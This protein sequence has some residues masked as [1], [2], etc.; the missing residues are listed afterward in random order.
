M[1]L[2]NVP[3]R[4]CR[5]WEKNPRNIKKSDFARLKEQK[6]ELG[7]YKPLVAVEENGEYTILGGNMRLRALKEMGQEE[8]AIVL[9]KAETEADKIKIALSDNDRA[10][11]YDD[12]AV[13]ELVWPH[14]EHIDLDRYHIDMGKSHTIATILSAFGPTYDTEPEDMIPKMDPDSTAKFGD[15]YE[16]QDHRLLCADATDP[17]AYA[18]LMDGKKADLV[19]TDPPYNVDY[20]SYDKGKILSDNMKP[21]VFVEFSV[22]FF[23]QLRQNIKP[24]GVF[25]VCSGYASYPTFIYAIKRVGLIF[26]CPIIWI[27]DYFSWGWNDY[28]HQHE[29]LLKVK[30]DKRRSA[31]PIL[32]GWNKGRHFF[33]DVRNEADVW[34]IQRRATTTMVHPTQKPL[35]LIKRA[36]RNS[37]KKGELILD[38]FAGGGSTLVAAHQM[39]RKTAIMDLD[40]RFIDV[41]FKRMGGQLEIDPKELQ[42]SSLK[43]NYAHQ[44]MAQKE[45]PAAAPLPPSTENWDVISTEEFKKKLESG[46]IENMP[47]PREKRPPVSPSNERTEAPAGGSKGEKGAIT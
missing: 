35:A 34:M 1:D 45:P 33:P 27:K 44:M 47:S 46:G 39:E 7:Q 11:E 18:I 9:V 30:A 8:V 16:I 19:F 2:L 6:R 22:T 5:N 37:S 4:K 38:P 43:G 14:T 3:I 36:L 26:S 10:G 23:E 24:G 12:Q 13:A 42:A 17:A 31:T 15:L 40:P 28:R 20:K 21:E 29:M 25:Y 41:M 32:Y